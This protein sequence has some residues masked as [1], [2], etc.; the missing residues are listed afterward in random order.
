M[1]V[2]LRTPL[3]PSLYA[4]GA[5]L[6]VEYAKTNG[7]LLVLVLIKCYLGLILGER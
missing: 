2:E 1:K 6:T 4:Q 7:A 3:E 5:L